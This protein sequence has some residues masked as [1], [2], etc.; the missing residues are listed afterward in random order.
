MSQQWFFDWDNACVHTA[1]VVFSWFDAHGVQRLELVPA[2]YFLLKK[3]KMGV[4]RPE[5]GPGQ[6]QE[7]LGGGRNISDRRRLRRHLQ[8]LGGTLQK[9]PSPRRQVRQKILRN[10]H[11]PSSNRCHFIHTFAFDCIHTSY[12][13]LA[14]VPLSVFLEVNTPTCFLKVYIL[15]T[16]IH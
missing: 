10:K 5:P 2:D 16:L 14:K 13:I 15:Q 12:S 8:K 1:A 9:A 11:P 7:R 4:D 6:H 3:T